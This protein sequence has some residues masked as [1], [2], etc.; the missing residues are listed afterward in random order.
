ML[1]MCEFS[2]CS[3]G[4]SARRGAESEGV[5]FTF[6]FASGTCVNGDKEVLICSHDGSFLLAFRHREYGMDMRCE[7][8][9][10]RAGDGGDAY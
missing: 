9:V 2:K 1:T 10:G 8:Q 3:V 7:I 5:D 4:S 6:L